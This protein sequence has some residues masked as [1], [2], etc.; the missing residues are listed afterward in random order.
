MTTYTINNELNYAAEVVQLKE[1]N[2]VRLE[3]L[4]RLVGVAIKG[5]VALVQKGQFQ[6]GDTAVLFP[7]EC[8]LSD[9]FC[10]EQGLYREDGG[11]IE[12]N[13]RV[14]AIKLRGH[15]S[16]ALL[17]SNT[18]DIPE[19]TIFDTIDGVEVCRKYVPRTDRRQNNSVA[20][21]KK[22]KTPYVDAKFFPEHMDTRQFHRF[23]ELLDPKKVTYI[24]QKLDGTSVRLGYTYVNRK[25]TLKE[26]I[27]KWFG[28]DAAPTMAVVGGS[29]KVVKT[30]PNRSEGGDF[31]D[32]DIWAHA[33]ERYGELI[34][35]NVIVYGELVG[36]VP[37]TSTPIQ[38][39]YTYN[40][41][42]GDYELYVYRVAVITSD[43]QE[44][45]LPDST[46]REFCA[47][48]G[49]KVVPL[50][51]VVGDDGTG[52]SQWSSFLAQFTDI[53]MAEQNRSGAL[54]TVE[55]PVPL[56]DP[57]TVDEG[58]VLRQDGLRPTL[59]KVKGP[60]FLQTETEQLDEGVGDYDGS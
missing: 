11:Y 8:Q 52:S 57:D 29:R 26:R 59:L 16:T 49:L 5:Q 44:Y 3:G 22:N 43:G 51:T 24:T 50:L 41:A 10:K 4:D 54:Y 32:V 15:Y 6:A 21:A 2:F 7:T 46:M 30:D 39:K 17:L 18:E 47:A 33:T 34:P 27:A 56:S 42:K 14:R 9:A 13:R 20:V 1:S 36:F 35:P 28:V 19:G 48:R 25:P 58:V 23:P 38:P 37:G 60:V 31:Y 45:D 55:P 53:R 40:V 12:K